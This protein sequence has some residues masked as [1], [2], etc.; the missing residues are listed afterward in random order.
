VII[1]ICHIVNKKPEAIAPLNILSKYPNV[2]NAI[3][4][5]DEK[6][7]IN[8]NDQKLNNALSI[9]D[10]NTLKV[11]VDYYSNIVTEVVDTSR[12]SP[13]PEEEVTKLDDNSNL[14]LDTLS[15]TPNVSIAE[16]VR[17]VSNIEDDESIFIKNTIYK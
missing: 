5:D 11:L 12:S 16:Y 2:V 13:I 3:K 6:V 9:L 15:N 10:N 1:K 14:E 17:G 7:L 8:D 4:N